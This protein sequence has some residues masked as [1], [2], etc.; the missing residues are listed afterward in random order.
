M[1]R[2]KKGSPKLGTIPQKFKDL[3]T[4]KQKRK[5]KENE[6]ELIAA[7]ETTVTLRQRINH[8]WEYF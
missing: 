5:L 1:S 4:R 6:R 7:P 3:N 2:S 8:A